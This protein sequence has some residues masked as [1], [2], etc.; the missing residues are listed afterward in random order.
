[1]KSTSDLNWA[2][3]VLVSGAMIALVSFCLCVASPA[4]LA[5]NAGTGAIAGTITDPTEKVV[6]G[7]QITATNQ[8]TG[9]KDTVKSQSGGTYTV[10]LLLPGLYTVEV[11]KDGFKSSVAKDIRV[12]VTETEGLNIKLE[13]GSESQTIVV[14][15]EASPM[16]TESSTEGHTTDARTIQDLPLATRNYTQIIGLNPNISTGVTNAT[17]LGRGNDIYGAGVSAN[18]VPT[19][20]N[21]TLMDGVEINDRQQ[22]GQFSSGVAIPNPDS[23]SEFRVQTSQ[24]DAS[25]GR[26]AGA[27]VNVV[28]KGGSNEFHGNLWEYFRDTVMN[29]N[30]YFL[31]RSELLSGK[32]NTPPVL[33]QNQFGGDLG[34]PIKK[35]KLLFFTSYQGTRSKNG[36]SGSCLTTINGIGGLTN[37]D[38]TAAGLG[39]VFAGDTGQFGGEAILANG[40]NISQ[41]AINLLNIKLANGQFLIPSPPAGQSS[42]VVTNLCPFNEDQFVTNADYIQSSKS[43]F[44][45]RFFFAND[46]TTETQPSAGAV[47]GTPYNITAN[48]RNFSLMHDYAFSSR[49]LNQAQFGFHR[50]Y[51]N[52]QGSSPFT[53]SSLGAN[54]P[55]FDNNYP[56]ILSESGFSIFP[57]PGAAG[58]DLIA[59]TSYAFQDSV[60]YTIGKHVLRFGGGVDH[61]HENRSLITGD[62]SV[63]FGLP[64]LLLGACGLPITTLCPGTGTSSVPA[65]FGNGSGISNIFES[66]DFPPGFDTQELINWDFNVYAQDDFKVTSRLTLNLGFRYDRNGYQGDALGKNVGF[67]PSLITP[68]SVP[69]TNCTT[70]NGTGSLLGY[71]VSSN[72]PAG[73]PPCQV[74]KINSESGFN[75]GGNNTWNPRVGFAWR[76]PHTERVVLRGGYGIYHSILTGQ[77]QLNTTEGQPF[78]SVRVLAAGNDSPA[79]LGQPFQPSTATFPSYTPYTAASTQSVLAFNPNLQVPMIQEYSLNLQTELAK[80]LVL[81]IGYSGSRGEH[82][83]DD[84]SVNQACVIGA[85]GNDACPASLPSGATTNTAANVQQ[86][87]PYEGIASS[88]LLLFQS[89]ASYWYNALVVG[90]TK[91]MGHGLQFQLSYTWNK[92]METFAGG[93]V[94]SGPNG[95]TVVGDA[96]NPLYGPDG[97]LRPQRFVASY[98]YDLPGPKNLRSVEGEFLGGWQLTGVTTYQAGAF[99]TITNNAN[100]S[101]IYGDTGSGAVTASLAAGCTVG[102]LDEP[103]S[104]ESKLGIGGTTINYFNKACLTTPAV[105]P[106]ATGTGTGFGNLGAGIVRGPDQANWD[107]SLGKR[108]NIRWPNDNANVMFRADFFNVFNHPQF[109]NPGTTFGSGT[110]GQITSTSVNPRII[111]LALRFNF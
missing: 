54:V 29:A 16:Q 41:Q 82:L 33:N 111:Q 25:F 77:P 99:L 9:A 42:L 55:S 31:K 24:Y 86:R 12:N 72:Y 51:T 67:N 57:A 107:V 61:L 95:A 14:Q 34:G 53:L 40:S 5:Q 66:E 96:N 87:V 3:L 59:Q 18:G 70:P 71:T 26:D 63:V 45:A 50:T 28:T 93:G 90:L 27:N 84:R 7:A 69:G 47:T 89:D 49:L 65:I 88:F 105:S 98:V 15:G 109:S 78:F 23:I 76:L 58:Q 44:S 68:F 52:A 108:F 37:T 62:L 46:L 83:F 80:N 79:S 20:D 4:A 64:D 30:D 75:P 106:F 74:V 32:P 36:F 10:P 91:R 22:S 6:L 104:V 110:F 19:N 73:T 48:Y 100:A 13:L 39:A 11:T 8:A 81:E 60:S 85:P 102:E 101:N 94:V 21:N 38:R 103:G 56:I 97:S 17:T 43:R 2:R 92:E 35:D 1:M